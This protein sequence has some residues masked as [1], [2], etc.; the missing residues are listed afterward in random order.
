MGPLLL[1][2]L[3]TWVRAALVALSTYLIQHHIVTA[4]Q[5]DRLM[6]EL[7]THIMLTAPALAAVAW[8]MWAK[9]KGRIR[10][11]TALEMPSGTSESKVKAIVADGDGAKL[12]D[13]IA[14]F[15][16]AT[17]VGLGLSSAACASARHAAVVADATVAQVV[18]AVDDAEWTVYQACRPA[19]TCEARHAK[20]NPPIKKAL[21]DVKGVTAALQATP[22]AGAPPTSLV[23]LFADLQ[24][25]NTVLD[26]LGTAPDL[27]PLVAKVR[28]AQSSA[29]DALSHFAGGK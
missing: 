4:D 13:V 16:I 2:I 20:L 25:V 8:S 10:F 9:Y 19:P 18:F 7:F 21:Q 28:A 29:I 3:G 11:L 24:T 17:L 22:S 12:K 1:D 14:A 15:F 5:G 6:T 23:D 26:A 27:A